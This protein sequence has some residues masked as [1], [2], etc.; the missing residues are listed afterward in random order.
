MNNPIEIYQTENG[1]TEVEVCFEQESVWLSQAQMVQLF[2][3]DVSVLF[4]DISEMR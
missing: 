4:Q 2:G 1:E 3:R